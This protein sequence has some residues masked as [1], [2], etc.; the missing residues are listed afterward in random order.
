ME[1]SARGQAIV[2]AGSVRR[3]A[4]QQ[5]WSA[6]NVIGWAY[7]RGRDRNGCAGR[8]GSV[9]VDHDVRELLELC[10]LAARP[11]WDLVVAGEGN[12]SVVTER[13]T[14]HVT[15]SGARLSDMAANA[16]TEIQPELLIAGLD[17]AGT[18]VE[19]AK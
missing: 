10:H 13:G 2:V 17:G 3:Y 11:E 12:A 7:R 14:L 18:D 8:G 5:Y 4:G 9:I 19:W 16:V 15:A 1:R 6:P